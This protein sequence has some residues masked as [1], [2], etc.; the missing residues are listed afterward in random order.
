MSTQAAEQQDWEAVYRHTRSALEQTAALFGVDS[1]EAARIRIQLAQMAHANG[2]P[3]Q[4][5][6]WYRESLD[7]LREIMGPNHP[8]VESLS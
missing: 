4:A 5:W 1:H 6:Q 7:Q 8:E 2:D 3:Q